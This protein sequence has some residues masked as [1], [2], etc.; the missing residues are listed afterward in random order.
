MTWEIVANRR[1]SSRWSLVAGFAHTWNADQTGGYLGQPV[2]NNTHPLTPNDLIHAS[3][4]GQYHFRTWSAKVHG[5]YAGPWNLRITPYLR[6]QSGQPF[7]RT[8]TTALNYGTVRILAEPIGMRRMDNVTIVDV[9][10]EK[11]VRLSGPRRLAGFIDL[12]NLFNSN[13]EQALI[14]SSGSSFLRPLSIVSPRIMRV[15][16]K[17]EW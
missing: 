5:T 11:G 15:G 17:L 7:G 8:F 1:F 10:V 14:W 4:N 12:F 6:H 3:D 2:R 9:R 16:A 13:A